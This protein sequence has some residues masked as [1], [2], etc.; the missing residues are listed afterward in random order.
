M[1]VIKKTADNEKLYNDIYNEV[2]NII[3]GVNSHGENNDGLPARSFKHGNQE[4]VLKTYRVAIINNSG[5][6]K[7]DELGERL[8]GIKNKIGVKIA[9]AN[10]HTT[11]FQ[12]HLHVSVDFESYK[13]PTINNYNKAEMSVYYGTSILVDEYDITNYKHN[14]L[15]WNFEERKALKFYNNFE[16]EC[17]HLRK[18]IPPE[19]YNLYEKTVPQYPVNAKMI[20]FDRLSNIE[21]DTIDGKYICKSC[22]MPLYRHIYAQIIDKT[23]I[24]L[25]CPNCVH[26]GKVINKYIF[27]T[28]YDVPFP[29]TTYFDIITEMD[30]GVKRHVF[31]DNITYAVIGD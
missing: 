3:E 26:G 31:D 12:K 2:L 24:N 1:R 27:R 4:Y 23:R 17:I 9:A 25:Y 21:N 7:V 13:F 29:Q 22:V 19:I 28:Y 15:V 11:A 20:S 5:L 10:S 6:N 16:D 8:A 14:E 18:G 30:K